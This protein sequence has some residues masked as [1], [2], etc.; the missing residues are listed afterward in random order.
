MYG[1]FYEQWAI[2]HLKHCYK[3]VESNITQKITTKKM[4]KFCDYHHYVI[5]DNKH[6]LKISFPWIIIS[7]AKRKQLKCGAGIFIKI[8]KYYLR[9]M[10]YHIVEQHLQV[11]KLKEKLWKYILSEVNAK[12][13]FFNVRM[14]FIINFVLVVKVNLSQN[15]VDNIFLFCFI[16]MSGSDIHFISLFRLPNQLINLCFFVLLHNF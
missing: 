3:F 10:F 1:S 6:L 13:I 16:V 14:Q 8:C 12:Q 15:N 9:F 4:K 11:V 2:F 5:R 7:H